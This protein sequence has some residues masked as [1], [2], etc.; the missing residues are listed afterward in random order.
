MLKV[1]LLV[2]SRRASASNLASAEA[3]VVRLRR[4]NGSL[5]SAARAAALA[6]A[7]ARELLSLREAEK[8]AGE[9]DGVEAA[10]KSL[11]AALVAEAESARAAKA[12]KK[13]LDKGLDKVEKARRSVY[14][15]LSFGVSHSGGAGMAGEVV[16]AYHNLLGSSPEAK[17]ARADFSECVLLVDNAVRA[18]H[19]FPDV[20]G[21]AAKKVQKAKAILKAER[22]RGASR[23]LEAAKV[24]LEKASMEAAAVGVVIPADPAPV[25]P[26]PADPAPVDPG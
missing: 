9:S 3:E 23:R 26:A 17:A 4:E 10:K 8:E 13:A 16:K 2:V 1:S 11:D 15:I 25:D 14:E 19:Q 24:E 22:S 5:S 20:A 18:S 12:A 6:V 7:P 21:N